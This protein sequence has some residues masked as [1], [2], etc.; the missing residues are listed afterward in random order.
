[1][2]PNYQKLNGCPGYELPNGATAYLAQDGRLVH[3]VKGKFTWTR[4]DYQQKKRGKR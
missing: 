3:Y 4:K 2:Q 1:M